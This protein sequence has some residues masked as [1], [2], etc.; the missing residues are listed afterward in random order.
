MT[1]TAVGKNLTWIHATSPTADD[2][3]ALQR[4]FRFHD[5]IARELAEPSSRGKAERHDGYLYLVLH[6]PR[7]SAVEATSLRGEVDCIVTDRTLITVT[8][9]DVEPVAAFA[10]RVRGNDPALARATSTAELLHEFVLGIDEFSLRQLRHVEEKV[11]RVGAELFRR[12]DRALLEEVSRIKR[13]VLDFSIIAASERTTI[14]SLAE[15]G[16]SLWAP[17]DAI[18]LSALVGSSLKIDYLVERLRATIESHSETLSQL[19]EVRTSEVLRRFSILGFLTFPLILYTTIA[20]Q[21]SVVGDHLTTSA[22]FWG[23]FAAVALF[24]ALLAVLFRRR[25]LL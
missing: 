9:D 6:A 5:L 23:A 15:T 8:Y 14:E 7:W 1:R 3:A 11:R 16:A 22:E 19:F 21:P 17:A 4:E 18:Y 25:G 24:V 20:L 13:D 12:Q 2:I 10:E